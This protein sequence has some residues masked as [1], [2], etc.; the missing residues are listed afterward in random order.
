M[1]T[2][3]WDVT[4]RNQDYWLIEKGQSRVIGDLDGPG[5]I[6]HFWLTV[7]GDDNDWPRKMLVRVY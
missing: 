1:R 7:F 4:G 5:R 3:S 2:S 6:T